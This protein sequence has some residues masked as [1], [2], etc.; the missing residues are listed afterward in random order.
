MK[1][2]VPFLIAAVI[3]IVLV[4][5]ALQDETVSQPGPAIPSVVE[6]PAVV[7]EPTRVETPVV[8][9]DIDAETPP[10]D[11]EEVEVLS[12]AEMMELL[13][14]YGFG[15][16]ETEWRDWAL[17]RGYPAFDAA[18][19]NHFYDQPYDQY[20]D[21]VLRG[22][23]D[24][25]DMW[26]QQILAKR[27]ATT[28]PAEAIEYYR[29]A[30]IRG[31]VYA[32]SEM[33]SLYS[34]ISDTRRETEFKSQNEGLAMEQ[35]YAMRDAP[36]SPEVA[37]YAWTAVAELAGTEPMF[38]NISASQFNRSL[39]DAEKEEG[40]EI[41]RSM[42]EEISNERA[43]LGMDDFN[44]KPPPIVYWDPKAAP[45][46]GGDN[47]PSLDLDGCRKVQTTEGGETSTIWVC[48]D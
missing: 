3:V 11:S 47:T 2:L 38:G 15:R 29:Q 48:A 8:E 1:L 13:R 22:L 30:A 9:V 4:V 25:G 10:E 42:Y 5:L 32:M 20:D 43:Q 6:S 16:L 14:E 45:T 23:A 36:V 27:L 19:G 41:A 28:N 26:A 12:N 7:D 35:V 44:R 18:S 34:R 40:C 39:T 33:A 46:C 21:D 17:S 24:N 31:S 37:G